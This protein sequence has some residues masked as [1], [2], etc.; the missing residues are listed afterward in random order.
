L[1]GSDR[2]AGRR[3]GGSEIGEELSGG[4]AGTGIAQ[5][6]SNF[7]EGH[8]DESTLRETWMRNFKAG[9]REDE[10]C[11]EENVEIEGAGAVGGRGV[12]ITTKETL[13]EEESGEEGS[14]SECGFN[15]DDGVDEAGLI[16]EADWGSG[17]ERRSGGDASDGRELQE[18]SCER[19]IGMA[20]ETRKVGAESDVGNWHAGMRVASWRGSR[21][22]CVLASLRI[23]FHESGRKETATKDFH[24]KI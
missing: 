12:T 23:G 5:I 18:G 4:E 20:G 2:G 14:R 11:V 16:C 10:T 21:A 3:V 17:I 22:S 6:G 15:G 8:E 1:K 7:G 24:I 13:D 19:G 9:L